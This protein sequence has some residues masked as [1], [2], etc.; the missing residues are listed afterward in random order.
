MREGKAVTYSIVARDPDTGELG[1]AVQTDY[2]AVGRVVPWLEA[3]V[4][5]VA[6]QSIAEI[7]Y[8]PLGLAGM[9]SGQSASETLA[10]LV[11]ADD[12]GAQRQ[13]AMVDAAGR[14]AVHTGSRCVEASGH[15]TGNGVSCQA[16]MMERDSVWGAML[17]A[18]GGAA[19]DL[20]AR[21]FAA[22]EAAE[23]EGGDIRGRQSAAVV[24]VAGERHDQ[25]WE[26]R[27]VD[28]RVD[29]H[30]DPVGELGRLLRFHRAYQHMARGNDLAR[31]MDFQGAA[32]EM[33][34]AA[35]LAPAEPQ[36]AFWR[37]LTLVG[38][39][40]VDEARASFEQARTANPRY[41]EYLRRVARAELIPD[42]QGFIDSLLPLSPPKAGP[43]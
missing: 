16:N 19:G 40:R 2:F 31:A 35:G 15:A 5:A 38:A 3:G 32:A 8:G 22:L 1:V 39:G 14:M 9:R 28:L 12:G 41:A 7:S 30:T 6:T 17:E 42:E 36:I 11:S 4:G 33:D 23:A 29:N 34:A 25:P 20:A 13:V 43:W 18:Y 21:L 10:A 24:V 27:L 26:G 37:G